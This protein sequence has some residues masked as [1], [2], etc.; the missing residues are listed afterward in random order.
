MQET[1]QLTPLATHRVRFRK[2]GAWI[3]LGAVLL[4]GLMTLDAQDKA[5]KTQAVT[6]T[7]TRDTRFGEILVIKETGVEVYNT[8]GLND[9]PAELWDKMDIEALKKQFGAKAVQ[10]N[11][12][13]FWMT[14]S[15]T[16]SLGKTESFGG[17]EARLAAI[18]D[19][20]IVA[21]SAK[22]SEP[23]KVFTPKKTQ[24]QVFAKGKPVFELIDPD[25][26]NYVLQAREEKFPMASLATL[27]AQMKQL[28][29]GWKY[30]TRVLTEDL[31]I[32]C[33][34]AETIYAVGDE[35]HQY[36]TRPNAAK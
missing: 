10:K 35:F 1:I 34:P 26:H 3:S 14:D 12:P 21:K 24:K 7:D 17:I 19:P 16:L 9:C 18:L 2:T 13:H 27:G 29:K 30:Q 23:Y 22:G 8:T 6:I 11:G 20:A 33:S 28:P 25:G 15:Q 5:D 36:Y 32:D 4:G 31:I